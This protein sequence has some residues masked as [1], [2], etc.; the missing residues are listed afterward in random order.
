MVIIRTIIIVLNYRNNNSSTS[1][2]SSRQRQSFSSFHS[3]CWV[4][5]YLLIT[6]QIKVK[7]DSLRYKN[8]FL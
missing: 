6:L 7:L 5:F 3:F 8:T 4:F 1:G 2:S